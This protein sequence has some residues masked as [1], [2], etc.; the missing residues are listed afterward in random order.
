M[1]VHDNEGTEEDD[2]SCGIR[3]KERLQPFLIST[4]G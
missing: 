2:G 1:C 3:D 4:G